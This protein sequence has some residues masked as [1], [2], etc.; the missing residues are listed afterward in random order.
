MITSQRAGIIKHLESGKSL[1]SLE[2]IQKYG[3]TKLA[4]RICEL[5]EEGYLIYTERETLKNRY[6]NSCTIA[7]YWLC[8]TKKEL[9]KKEKDYLKKQKGK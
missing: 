8:K 9:A 6:G 3:C 4:S 7:R 5:K 2:A 1:T